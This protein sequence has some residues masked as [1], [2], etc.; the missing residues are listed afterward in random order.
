[1]FEDMSLSEIVKLLAPVI[2]VQFSLMIFVLYRLSKDRVKYLPKWAWVLI[3]IFV[4]I[5]GPLAYLII[6]RDGDEHDKGSEF[7]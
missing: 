2:L 3:I 1:M 4:N 7:K 5:I 6:G